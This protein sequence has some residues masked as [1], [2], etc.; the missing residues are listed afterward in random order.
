MNHLEFTNLCPWPSVRSLD[1]HKRWNY[2]TEHSFIDHKT[3]W[4]YTEGVC[5]INESSRIYQLV[6][7]ASVKFFDLINDGILLFTII[8]LTTRL[9]AHILKEYE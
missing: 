6:S 4:P 3:R 1:V 7:M 2:F 9:S 8:L 5:I